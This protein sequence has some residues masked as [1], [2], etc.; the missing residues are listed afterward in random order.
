MSG[1]AT[2]GLLISFAVCLTLTP[3][4]R[5]LCWRL[6]MLDLPGPLKIHSRPIPRLGGVAVA[7]S[8]AAGTAITIGDHLRANAFFF[9]ALGALWITGIADDLRGL[10]PYARLAAQIA[11]GALLWLGGW[12]VLA[13]HWLPAAGAISLILVCLAVAVFANAFNFLD[14]S[15]GLAAGVAAIASASWLAI[16]CGMPHDPLS[17]AVAACLAGACSAF[18]LFNFAP[19]TIHL[20]DSGSTI[21]GFC[22]AL[23]AL[24]RPGA[25]QTAPSFAL[26]TLLISAVPIADFAFA[27]I[28]RLRCRASLLQGDR[29]HLYD[30]MLARGRSPRTVALILYGITAGLGFASWLSLRLDFAGRLT[31]WVLSLAGLLMLSI[32][33][34]PLGGEDRESRLPQPEKLAATK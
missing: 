21:V 20:G 26:M 2:T 3:V 18:L 27:I 34:G 24:S 32:R 25:A 11:S 5:E 33:L 22:V 28:R 23:L 14:G 6:G 12:R 17:P 1:P 16:T 30:Q 13:G 8:I 9:A 10:S 29:L 19:A 15:D 4:T 7:L 31:I